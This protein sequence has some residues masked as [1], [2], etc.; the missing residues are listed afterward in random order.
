MSDEDEMS[1]LSQW[2]PRHVA[3][4]ERWYRITLL[5]VVS[6]CVGMSVVSMVTYM[7]LKSMC[8]SHVALCGNRSLDLA[9]GGVDAS[10]VR[11]L[12][13]FI[14]L[15]NEVPD[16][17]VLHEYRHD[18]S[19]V[20]HMSGEALVAEDVHLMLIQMRTVLGIAIQQLLMSERDGVHHFTVSG[21]H[22]QS[23]QDDLQA[24]EDDD[25]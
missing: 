1:I 7:R 20:L 11:V 4:F 10:D 6:A 23:S 3:A 21:T 9:G 19:G 13:C 18:L 25:A 15:C 24:D 12:S 2:P 5:A 14:A 17:V 22:L 16:G 8:A